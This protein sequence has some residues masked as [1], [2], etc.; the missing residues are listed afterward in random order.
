MAVIAWNLRFC[1]GCARRCASLASLIAWRLCA[2]PCLVWAL[3]LCQSAFLSP[4]CLPLPGALGP[5]FY[6]EAARD[7]LR[8]A[9]NRAHRPCR[10]LR[11]KGTAWLVPHCNP[12]GLHYEVVPVKSLGSRS[13]ALCAAVVLHFSGP[14]LTRPVS[15]TMGLWMGL[16]ALWL[17]HEHFHTIGCGLERPA[18]GR[19]C[20]CVCVCVLARSGVLIRFFRGLPGLVLVCPTAPVAVLVLFCP[21]SAP[22][23]LLLPGI[24]ISLLLHYFSAP[25]TLPLLIPPHAHCF[26]PPSS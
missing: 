14:S 6:R 2:V 26:C 9:P 5:K 15:R 7:T 13:W 24:P 8:P 12:F 20:V 1:P 3:S 22:S 19:V 11:R 23:G 21:L 17:L 18:R 16:L 10:G 4:W 25:W